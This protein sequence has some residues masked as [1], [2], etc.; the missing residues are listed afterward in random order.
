MAAS[1]HDI[2]LELGQ[3]GKKGAQLTGLQD[4][5]GKEAGAGRPI[6]SCL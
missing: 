6:C 5:I 4:A 2:G 1:A 3:F